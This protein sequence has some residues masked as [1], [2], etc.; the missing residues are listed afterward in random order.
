MN[1]KPDMSNMIASRKQDAEDRYRKVLETID[2]FKKEGRKITTV[3][4]YNA[5]GVS[6]NYFPNHKELYP[7]LN[8]AKG[9]HANIRSQLKMIALKMY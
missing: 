3:S 1:K 2:L 9:H 7:V 6:N 5:A 4:I 8:D